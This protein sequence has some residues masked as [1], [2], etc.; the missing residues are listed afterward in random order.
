MKLSNKLLTAGIS[1]AVVSMFVIPVSAANYQTA[2]EII[3]DLT[4][5]SVD[6]VRTEKNATGKTYGQMALESGV[7]E[8]FKADMLELK[9]ERLEQKVDDGVLSQEEAN[10]IVETIEERQVNCDGTGIN[11]EDGLGLGLGNGQGTGN[12]Q[13]VGNGQG[14]GNGQGAGNGQA[15]GHGQGTGNGKGAGNGQ[16]MRDGSCVTQ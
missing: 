12:G 1:L 10:T 3:A 15:T 9:K 2:A 13:G 8:Q 4:G 6:T 14:T 11:K 16:G 5:G 7:L